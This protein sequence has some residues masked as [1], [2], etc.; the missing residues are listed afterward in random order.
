MRRMFAVLAAAI[1][2]FALA[3]PAAATSG[4]TPHAVPFHMQVTG[5]D[6]PLEMAP[7]TP[8]FLDRS[9]FGGRCTVPS[10]WVTTVDSTGT[11]E[12]MGTISVVNSHC[13][14]FD[15]LS[16]PPMPGVF[17]DGR[18][19]ITAANGDQLWVEYSGSFQFWPSDRP[20]AGTS[21]IAMD[22]MTIVG[23]TGRFVDAS[24]SL[25]GNAVDE[26]GTGADVG[27]FSGWI[28]YSASNRAD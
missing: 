2:A 18:M 7:G 28:L 11:A 27:Q 12:H 14:R 21:Y 3:A 16:A 9:T 22:Q 15:F 1:L 20:D 8:P 23:G 24:G 17:G 19:T 6:R 5:V 4:Q 26:F 25:L 13:T 10:D